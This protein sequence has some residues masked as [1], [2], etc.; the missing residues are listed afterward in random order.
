MTAK[1]REAHIA[2]ATGTETNAG[3]ADHMGTIEHLVEEFPGTCV[4]RRT[5]PQVRG[6]LS[7]ID[8]ETQTEERFTKEG[9]VLHIVTDGLT[10]LLSALWRIDGRSRPLGDVAGAVELRRLSAVPQGI[11]RNALAL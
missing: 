10:H 8:L 4:L 6:M 2:L 11:E 3:G 7:S 9:G 5:H 1:G